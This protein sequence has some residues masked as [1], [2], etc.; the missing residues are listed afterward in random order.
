MKLKPLP[1]LEHE[2]VAR[3][4]EYVPY[5]SDGCWNWRGAGSKKR[6]GNLGINSEYFAAH[7]LSWMVY[8]GQIPAGLC[9]CHR[10]DNT[11]CVNP[12]HLFL[13]TSAENL[14]DCYSKDRR[15]RMAGERN[16]SSKLTAAQVN[17]I[18]LA[19]SSGEGTVALARRFGVGRNTVRRLAAGLSWRG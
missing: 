1:S 19:K 8:R 14:L 6:Y 18:R 9:V 15:P 13:G 11:K 17:E 12:E 5:W 2:W 10:C 16:P 3:F 4:L 7:R